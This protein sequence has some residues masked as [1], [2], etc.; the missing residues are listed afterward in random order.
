MGLPKSV[1]PGLSAKTQAGQGRPVSSSSVTFLADVGIGKQGPTYSIWLST[2]TQ[3]RC[4]CPGHTAQKFSRALNQVFLFL[5]IL[6]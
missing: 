6:P 3:G 5:V 2:V 4:G 1:W